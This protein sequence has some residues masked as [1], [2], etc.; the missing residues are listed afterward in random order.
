VAFTEFSS[1]IDHS[2]KQ[3]DQKGH[4]IFWRAQK[5][6]TFPFYGSLSRRKV[7]T[8]QCLF[9]PTSRSELYATLWLLPSSHLSLTTA[10]NKMTKKVI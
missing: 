8:S 1:F 9:S 7:Q 5:D 3:N 4:L 10:K 2:K 6:G